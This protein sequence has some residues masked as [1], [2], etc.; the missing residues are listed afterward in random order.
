MTCPSRRHILTGAAGLP[1]ALSMVTMNSV[2]ATA[3]TGS[4]Q[5][6]PGLYHYRIGDARVSAVNDGIQ[7]FPLPDDLVRNAER[8]QV[9]GALEAAFLPKDRMTIHYNPVLVT[10]GGKRVL[11]DTGNGPQDGNATTGKLAANLGWANVKP[12]EIDIVIVSHFHGDHI[13][14]LRT[15]QGGLAF[16]D[17]EILVPAKEWAYWMDE[18][19][20]SRAPEALKRNFANVRRVFKDIGSRVRPYE[21]DTEVAP[22]LTAVGTPGHTPG[23]TSFVLASGADKLFIQADV[24]NNPALF[25]VNPDWQLR[26]DMDGAEA[27]QTRRRIYDML[28]KERMQV[29]GFHFPF[30]AT[31]FVETAGSGYRLVPAVWNPVL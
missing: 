4:D 6:V 1:A 14:G 19:E 15:A 31:G 8:A 5:Q 26:F 9:N 7:S 16:P 20:A 12:G 27:A 30:P 13:N 18:G 10:T 29:T 2:T 21:W 25:V 17:A 28:A 22:G 23:H 24:T 3:Q 11:I